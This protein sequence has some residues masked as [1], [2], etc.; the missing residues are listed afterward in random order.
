MEALTTVKGTVIIEAAEGRRG[1]E[2]RGHLDLFW[3]PFVVW[4]AV[5]EKGRGIDC[6]H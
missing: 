6:Q 2:R 3:K 1:S 4:R 5:F